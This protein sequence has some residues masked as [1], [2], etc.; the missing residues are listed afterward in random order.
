MFYPYLG[1][2]SS[3]NP[4]WSWGWNTSTC[5]IKDLYT[6]ESW[7]KGRFLRTSGG[8][9]HLS[10]YWLHVLCP[11][12]AFF[13]VTDCRVRFLFKKKAKWACVA[14]SSS[15]LPRVTFWHDSSFWHLPNLSDWQFGLALIN[16]IKVRSR[17]NKIPICIHG[18]SPM[19]HILWVPITAASNRNPY[20]YIS[21]A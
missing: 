6:V 12:S 14:H 17:E 19:W 5:C 7:I 4:P 2:A 15:H 21:T 11:L 3:P 10:E 13:V 20:L 1:P 16:P 9:V 8:A 18:S